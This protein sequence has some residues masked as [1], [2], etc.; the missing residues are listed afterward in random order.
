MC[1]KGYNPDVVLG[2]GARD[3]AGQAILAAI[4]LAP[5]AA[6][7]L[8]GNERPK[9]TVESISFLIFLP[10]HQHHRTASVKSDFELSEAAGSRPSQGSKR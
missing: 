4:F 5:R 2:V 7:Y 9:L 8:R 10:G 6:Y 1:G 3:E